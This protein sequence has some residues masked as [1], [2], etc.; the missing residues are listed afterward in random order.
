MENKAILSLLEPILGTPHRTSKGNY[1][2]KCP[3]CHHHKN[4]LE[5]NIITNAKMENPWHCWVCEMRGKTIKTL[6]KQLTPL[7]PIAK[8]SLKELKIIITPGKEEKKYVSDS[9]GLPKEYISLS[10]ILS[11]NKTSQ[12]EAK[13]AIKFLKSRGLNSVD[14][15]KYNIGFCNEGIYSG[16]VIIPSYDRNGKLNYFIARDY[17]GNSHQK[18]KNPPI[19]NKSI[20][21]WELY[22]NWDA[23]IILVE[24]I[25][26][27]LTIKRN[28]IPLFGKVINET[29]MKK[30]SESKVDRI[31]LALDPDAMVKNT[32]KYCEEL[33][34]MGKEVYLIEING[35]DINEI[36]FDAFLQTIENTI[37]LT[38]SSLMRKKLDYI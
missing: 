36:G 34:A 3:F 24:G 11:L 7:N 13:H 22:I 35:K 31:Y 4:K 16:R 26:D 29:L 19:D 25:F 2:F 6:L 21:G 28:V 37:P 27:A 38:F 18:Y 33:M 32:L 8:H 20:I 23:P 30:I 1:A 17:T 5:V 14:V 10:D 9:I 12:I 15:L